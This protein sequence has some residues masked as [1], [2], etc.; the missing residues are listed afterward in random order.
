[1]V[2]VLLGVASAPPYGDA[3]AIGYSTPSPL[4]ISLHGAPTPTQPLLLPPLQ[5]CPYADGWRA[6]PLRS[7]TE[8]AGEGAA[9]AAVAD[10]IRC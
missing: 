4:Y 9:P 5:R 8:R 2:V 6:F 7:T 1:M 3:S 10:G